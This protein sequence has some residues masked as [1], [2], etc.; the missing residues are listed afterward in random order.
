[1]A[2]KTYEL[3]RKISRWATQIPI[4]DGT[5]F[6]TFSTIGFGSNYDT[7]F[8]RYATAR[9]DIQ[10]GIEA[11]N[12]FKKGV[13]KLLKTDEIAESKEQGAK[14]KE[15]GAKGGE[16]RAEIVTFADVTTFRAAQAILTEEPYNVPKTSEEIKNKEAVLKKA[17]ELGVSFP[18]LKA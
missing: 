14:G 8:P 7:G 13:I 1:M 18:N 16:Q 11:S 5:E 17:A 12:N 3:K 9:E 6:V 10:Q 2:Y 4:K 15:P